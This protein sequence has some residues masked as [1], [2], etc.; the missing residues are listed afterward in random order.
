MG[1]MLGLKGL[2][3]NLVVRKVKKLV[4]AWS[5]PG[6]RPSRLRLQ[7]R[8]PQLKPVE[9]KPSDVAFLQYTGGTTG[10]SKGA[11]LTHSNVLANVAAGAVARNAFWQEAVRSPDL[12]CALPLYHI[13]ALTVNSLM[14]MQLGGTTC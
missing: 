4:P 6:T 13:F 2:I 7:R 3:V 10:V 14:G 8:R 11:M 1:D 5:L 12:L 9:V